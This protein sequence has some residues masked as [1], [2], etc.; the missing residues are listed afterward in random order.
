MN[1]VGHKHSD[2]SKMKGGSKEEQ[3]EPLTGW[4]N[5]GQRKEQL[6]NSRFGVPGWLSLLG[7]CLWL[8]S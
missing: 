2:H 3:F 6:R 8:R 1:S 7:V 4:L 5:M